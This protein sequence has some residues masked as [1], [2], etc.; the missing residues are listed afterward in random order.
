MGGRTPLT[1]IAIRKMTKPAE[2]QVE[3][4][5]SKVPGFGVRITKAGTKSF[6][7]LY[8]H[9][10]KPRRMTLGR[11]PDTG[12]SDARG[13]A[14]DAL[15]KV[16]RGEDP[17]G[18]LP[19]RYAMFRSVVDEFV[20]THCGQ[21]NRASTAYETERLLRVEFIPLWG[22]HA[23]A[24]IRKADVLSVLDAIVKR[25]TPSLANHALAAVRKLFNWGIE[26]GH[27]E[28]SPC[29]GIKRPSRPSSRERV[30]NEE[31][32]TT[33]WHASEELGYQF[34]TM[35]QLLALTA[36]RRGEVAGMRWSDLDLHDATWTIPAELTKNHRQHVVPLTDGVLRIIKSVPRVHEEWV[37]P[38]RGNGGP[39]AG[40]SKAKRRLDG[41]ANAKRH[42]DAI[43]QGGEEDE[44]DDL[45]WTLHDLRRTAATGMAKL[46]VAPHVV[47]RVLNHVSGQFKGV[48]GVYNRFGYLPEMREALGKWETHV[49]KLLAA[50]ERSR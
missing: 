10:G 36:Q 13:L 48:A 40:F 50:A 45:E 34:G 19:S 11:Y 15:A 20:E 17:Q 42:L 30:L 21:H 14:Q 39:F 3:T 25:G 31:E 37:F 49:A 32:L 23:F 27:L 12:L 6:V 7:F 4:W 29:M 43:E 26:R 18:D 1:D 38:A 28:F 41:A 35:F 46:G 44:V 2:G 8:R 33:L 5:D 47:E 16:K 9:K 22:Q 24:E